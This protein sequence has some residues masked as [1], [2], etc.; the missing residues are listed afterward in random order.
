M[1][2][3]VKMLKGALIGAGAVLPGISGGVLAVLF[4]L[5]KPLMLFLAN[6]RDATKA[7]LRELWPVLL[8]AVMGYVGIA[9]GLGDLLEGRLRTQSLAVFVGMTLGML[10]SLFSEAGERGRNRHSWMA[11]ALA[12]AMASGMLVAADT[13]KSMITPGFGWN[14][15]CGAALA[16]SI[17]APGMSTSVILMPLRVETT[18][19]VQGVA[20]S[21][22]IDLY[23]H[24]MNAIKHFD[25]AALTAVMLGMVVTLM[26]L[27]K[28]V[29]W[30][31][32]KHYSVMF[33]GIVAIVIAS[34]AFVFKGL[35]QDTTVAFG[36]THLI[37]LL[38]GLIVTLL[39][40]QFNAR[41]QK[42]S[43]EE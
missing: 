31:M 22:I 42:P 26:L 1:N 41:V 19:M 15:F 29:G 13:A 33:H 25:I 14:M 8:G 20:Q 39:L 4:G 6:P 2:L 12:L 3:M 23:T 37:C 16:L 27:T 5:Y 24:T 21:R 35:L 38:I 7:R 28:A 18:E 43:L 9:R 17:I 10:P 34:T 11:F 30:L 40:E 32:E 36:R